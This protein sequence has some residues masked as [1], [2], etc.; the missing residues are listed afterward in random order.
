MGYAPPV[1]PLEQQAGLAEQGR[2][3][4]ERD[5]GVGGGERQRVPG[6]DPDLGP[7]V[8]LARPSRRR[9]QQRGAAGIPAAN[10]GG[11]QRDGSNPI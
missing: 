2:R 11:S 6:R 1:E 5:A 10:V 3:D 9:G 4:V 8:G 7:L